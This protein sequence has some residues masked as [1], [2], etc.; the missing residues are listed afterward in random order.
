MVRGILQE[1]L[2]G[3]EQNFTTIQ[4]QLKR[5]DS[6]INKTGFLQ[7]PGQ[8]PETKSNDKEFVV[9][10]ENGVVAADHEKCSEIGAEVLGRLGGTAVDAAV[11][12]AFCLGVMNPSSSGIGGGA[13]MVVGSSSGSVATAYDMRETAPLA[14]SQDMFENREAERVVGPLSIAVP[15]EIAGLYKAW[16]THGRVQWKLLVEPSI[17]LARDGFEVGSHLAFAISKN[18]D[19]IKNDIG[20][21]RVFTNGDKFLKKGDICYNPKLAET[22]EVVAEKGMKAFYEE[23]VAEKLVNDVRE[24]GGIM[25][26]EDLRSYEVKVTDAMVVDDVM[27]YKIQGMWPPA[28]GTTGFAMVMNVLERYKKVTD[29]DETFGLHRLIEVM[30]HMLAARMDLGDPAF[31]KGTS[32]IVE[33]LL[34]KS[35]AERIQKK[36]SDYTTFPPEYYLNKYNQLE[37][38][39]TTHFC[40]VDKDRNAVSMTT[41]LNYAFGSGFMSPTTG[42]ILNGQMEDFAIP[43]LNSPSSLPPAPA[44]FIAPKKRALSSMM[45]LII[46]KDKELVGVIGASGGPYIFPAVI[47]VFLNHFIFKM[48]PLEAVQSP[49]VYPKLKPNEVWYEDMKVYNGDH[50]KLK[51]ETQEFL[52]M[53]RHKLVVTT[54][55]GIVQFVVQNRVH[56]SKTVLTAVSDLRK[57]GKP[58]AAKC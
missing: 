26:M 35:Y 52:K 55:G 2:L 10:S 27:G 6:H 28:C 3:M 38:Q 13:L 37:D 14:A 8:D 43:T 18:E 4:E 56:D 22:L 34:S 32:N 53:R 12:V 47:Q 29:T 19:M 11:A 58:A 54:V 16:E 51:E 30:K 44:N 46:T 7:F 36:I 17:K 20:L 31:V 45:P 41:T 21:K 40:V 9:T 15:G 1:A 24:A 48:S 5:R 42:V 50:I 33:N 23:D 25:T 39:G 57:D 49:R